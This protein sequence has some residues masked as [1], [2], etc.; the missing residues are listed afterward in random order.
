MILDYAM[1]CSNIYRNILLVVQTKLNPLKIQNRTQLSSRL[2]R[3][4]TNKVKNK[5]KNLFTD[6]FFS[7]GT[8]GGM[9]KLSTKT[10]KYFKVQRW[11]PASLQGPPEGGAETA[12][13]GEDEGGGGGCGAVPGLVGGEGQGGG[14]AGRGGQSGLQ[15]G[16]PGS[17]T[18]LSTGGLSDWRF[19]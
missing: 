5:R 15:Q 9:R 1:F 16:R 12:G 7:L 2:W 18:V 3:F 4:R 13:G 14:L 17:K 10:I 19:Q 11:E 8:K 6:G